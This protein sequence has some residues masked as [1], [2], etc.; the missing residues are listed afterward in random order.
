MAICKFCHGQMSWGRDDVADRWIPLVPLEEH[1]G[2]TRTFMDENGVLR[3]EHRLICPARLGP[4]AV[5]V[6][7]LAVP[8]QGDEIISPMPQ[9]SQQPRRR[10]RKSKTS[11]AAISDDIPF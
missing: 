10:R 8:V 5:R 9:E 3:A 6:Q 11:E 1:E 7:R 2:L 4:S